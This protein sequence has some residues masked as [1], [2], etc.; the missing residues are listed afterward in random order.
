MKKTINL[1]WALALLLPMAAWAQLTGTATVNAG[2][3]FNFNTG[4]VVGSGAGDI[5]FSGS[6]ITFVGTAKGGNLAILDVTGTTGYNG[7][8]QT[9][10][11]ELGAGYASAAPIS[12]NSLTAGTSNGSVLGILT[13]NGN[14][15]KLLITALSAS[16]IS[17]QY[18]TYGVSATGTSTPTVTNIQNNSSLIPNGFPNSGIAPSTLFVIHGSAMASATTVTG[19]QNTVPGL[20]T[21]LNGATVTISAGGQTFTPGLYYAEATQIAGVLPAAVPVGS[22]T[23]TVSYNNVQSSP[24]TFQVVPSAYGVDT[25][26]GNLAVLQ[27]AV[28]ASLISYTSSAKAGQIVLVWGTGLGSDPADS[29]TTQTGTPHTINTAVQIYVGGVQVPASSIAYVGAS[30]YPGVHIIQFT[31]PSGVPNGCFVPLAIIT[32][33]GTVSN[34]ATIPYMDAGGVCSDT[35]YGISGGTISTI[36]GSTNTSEGILAVEQITSPSVSGSGT[37]TQDLATADFVQISG[38]YSFTG[39]SS[40]EVSIGGCILNELISSTGSATSTLTETGLNAGTVT[41]TPPGGS[42]TTLQSITQVPGIY[43]TVLSSIPTAGGTYTFN[44]TGG[45][46]A[47][48]VGAGTA[49]V[50]FISPLTWTNQ[51]A[52]ATVTRSAGQTY[53]WTGGTPNTFVVVTGNSFSTSTGATGSY[54]CIANAS[55]GTITVPAYITASLPAGTG[56]STIENSSAVSTF[57]ASGLNVGI[58][59]G[60]VVVE[61]NTTWQ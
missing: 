61:V 1:G 37:T 8:S 6:A 47:N 17:F 2:Q 21:T 4:N 46:G 18:T 25:Y 30:V 53:N 3:N 22:A 29:D 49:T 40:S 31:L 44:W 15:A 41:V 9:E 52:S 43:D 28:S 32:G 11:Q 7:V 51:S 36:S 10:L 55:A 45:S 24:L 27:D 42:A 12:T 33:S 23:L 16:S 34:V 19:L 50:N 59:V 39:S 57:S 58:A 26:D 48:S 13:N 20:P 14:Y 54:T 35:Y 60:G 5:S 56:G 38:T